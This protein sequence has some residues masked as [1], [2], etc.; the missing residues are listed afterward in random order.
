MEPRLDQPE[1]RPG[2]GTLGPK[3][4]K[5]TGATGG[6]GMLRERRGTTEGK[7]SRDKGASLAQDR[8]CRG[9]AWR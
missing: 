1:L 7:E 3:A 2:P 9:E 6:R 4:E 8:E 5:A